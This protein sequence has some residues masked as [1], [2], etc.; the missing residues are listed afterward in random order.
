MDVTMSFLILANPDLFFVY[1]CPLI[2]PITITVS[3]LTIQIEKSIGCVLWIQTR[4]RRIVS[5]D[6]TTELWRPSKVMVH[7]FCPKSYLKS[8]LTKYTDKELK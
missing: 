3:S 4:G 8:E 6:K 1:F 5:A 2:V 7:C